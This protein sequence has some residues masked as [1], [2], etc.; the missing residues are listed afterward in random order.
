MYY[1]E[2][3]GT[4][5]GLKDRVGFIYRLNGGE[6]VAVLCQNISGSTETAVFLCD[7]N[8]EEINYFKALAVIKEINVEAVLNLLNHTT[9]LDKQ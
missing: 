5:Y 3:H 1:A 9:K 8:G 2:A 4:I 7:R 6:F